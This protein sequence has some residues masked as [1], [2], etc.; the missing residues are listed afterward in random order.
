MADYSAAIRRKHGPVQQINLGHGLHE[1]Q[2][3]VR[4]TVSD[5]ARR[6]I[7]ARLLAHNHV[8]YRQEVGQGLHEQGPRRKDF[9]V[10]ARGRSQKA[11][12]PATSLFD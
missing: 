2:Q 12:D 11:S 4:F 3:G 7:L 8:R 1:T 10:A 6:E 5:P 9:R